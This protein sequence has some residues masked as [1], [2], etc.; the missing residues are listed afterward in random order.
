MSELT[1]LIQVFSPF[2]NCRMPGPSGF[3]ELER[4]T[5]TAITQSSGWRAVFK[6]VTVMTIAT[7]AA[8]LGGGTESVDGAACGEM[9]VKRLPEAGPAGAAV[10]FPVG[11][12]QGQVAAGADIGSGPVF[13]VKLAAAGKLGFTEA[14]HRVLLGRQSLAPGRVT[15][16]EFFY[17]WGGWRSRVQLAEPASG[18]GDA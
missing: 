16:V 2:T 8:I 12:E 3:D 6:D 17:L 13:M 4:S 7:R 15:Q 10:V 1:P 18:D 5:I 9:F 14:Q 11:F